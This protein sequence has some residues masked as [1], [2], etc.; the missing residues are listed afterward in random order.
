MRLNQVHKLYRAKRLPQIT[1]RKHN[2][3]KCLGSQFIADSSFVELPLDCTS[4]EDL[5]AIDA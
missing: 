5:Q 3:W 1:M 4:V 2:L